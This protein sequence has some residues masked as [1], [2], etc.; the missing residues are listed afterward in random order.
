[1]DDELK[2]AVD[3]SVRYLAI[4]ARSRAELLS[5]LARKGFSD[6]TALAAIERLE[7]YG[8]IDDRAFARSF[9]RGIVE[10]RGL[11]RRAARIELF[12]KGVSE[13]DSDAAIAALDDE[14]EDEATVARRVAEKKLV[15]L[16]GV[17]KEKA[18]R[19]LIDHLRRR[20]FSFGVINGVIR[21]IGKD[22]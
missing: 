1:M 21:E 11:S 22:I 2:R 20:G 4:R 3:L 16:R 13:D 15:S 8:Y 18:R 6:D 10:R 12:R 14:G 19:R 9:A 7:S 5:Y 17:D